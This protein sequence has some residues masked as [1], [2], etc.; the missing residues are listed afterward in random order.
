MVMKLKAY[1][2]SIAYDENYDH[3]YHGQQDQT[4]DDC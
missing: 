1:R 2:L 3:H 4:A